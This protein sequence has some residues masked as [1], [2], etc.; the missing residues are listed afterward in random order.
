MS[1]VLAWR[2]VTPSNS[3][4]FNVTGTELS[5][6]V[7]GQQSRFAVYECRCWSADGF[8][9][10]EYV[11]RDADAVSD[12]DLAAGKRP[13]IVGRTRDYDNLLAFVAQQSEGAP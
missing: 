5:V 2:T 4:K 11:V 13:P 10:R 7:F 9:D 6:A 12:A 3:H 8:P 1:A